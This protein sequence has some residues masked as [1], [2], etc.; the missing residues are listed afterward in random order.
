MKAESPIM[1]KKNLSDFPGRSK[2]EWLKVITADLKGKD[3]NSLQ[4]EWLSALSISPFQHAED[5]SHIPIAIPRQFQRPQLVQSFP[6][7]DDIGNQLLQALEQGVSAPYFPDKMPW[8]SFWS[9]L[10]DVSWDMLHPI[11]TPPLPT[12]TNPPHHPEQHAGSFYL[13]GNNDQDRPYRQDSGRFTFSIPKAG[14]ADLPAQLAAW[15]IEIVSEL[16]QLDAEQAERLFQ[17]AL[18][19]KQLGRNFFLELAALRAMRLLGYHIQSEYNL[20]DPGP[21][22]LWA[23]LGPELALGSLQESLIAY[24][25]AGFAAVTGGADFIHIEAPTEEE[26]ELS[27]R[28]SRNIYHLFDMESHLFHVID[29]AA[30]SYAIENLS[31]TLAQKTWSEFQGLL[32]SSK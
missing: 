15:L 6:I 1:S 12:G 18:H 24:T 22:L 16:D 3:I 29:P 8:E 21:I 28:L 9:T 14:A 30:G 10:E 20:D 26:T 2:A 23:D 7:S 17:N 13:S 19:K 5:L 25:T 31:Q 11:W 27:Q 4:S 32:S